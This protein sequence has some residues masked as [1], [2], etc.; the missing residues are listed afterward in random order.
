VGRPHP[1]QH[2]AHRPH[3]R[4]RRH[5]VAP[6][7]ADFLFKLAHGATD[8]L[9]STLCL[10]RPHHVPLLVAPAMNVEMW[11]KAP[12]QRNVAQLRDD[13]VC[14]LGPAAG[15]QACGETAWAACSNRTN[16]SRNSSRRSSRS[17]WRASAC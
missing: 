8:D 9:L 10:A 2:G 6:C 11:E 5:P 12:T 13:G 17:S 4:R 15:S 3:A 7:S 1:Q 16:C 14:I